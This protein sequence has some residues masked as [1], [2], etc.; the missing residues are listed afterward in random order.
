M[1]SPLLSP[2]HSSRTQLD[3]KRPS[4]ALPG[5]LSSL[6]KLPWPSQ[7][8]LHQD[9]QPHLGQRPKPALLTSRPPE[10]RTAP[11][12]QWASAQWNWA[13]RMPEASLREQSEQ[14]RTD[15]MTSFKASPK[16]DYTGPS[17]PFSGMLN[18]S[19]GPARPS[20]G[21]TPVSEWCLTEK[22]PNKSYLCMCFKA[23]QE[24]PPIPS[25]VF[26][27]EIRSLWGNSLQG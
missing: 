13:D 22:A 26:P 27:V 18:S 1:L 10:P 24:L 9:R 5:R 7:H 15:S 3:S 21:H 2:P 11:R 25:W 14:E 17:P 12:T 6:P 8:G 19:L 23:E 4:Q 16:E 20:E